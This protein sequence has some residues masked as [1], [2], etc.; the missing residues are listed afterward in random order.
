MA[1]NS[2]VTDLLIILT[3]IFNLFQIHLLTSGSHVDQILGHF[4]VTE[5]DLIRQTENYKQVMLFL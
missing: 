5:M 1:A 2:V 3:N 4:S